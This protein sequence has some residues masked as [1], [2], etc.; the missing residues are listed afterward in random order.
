MGQ[1]ASTTGAGGSS[2]AGSV[3]PSLF[4]TGSVSHVDPGAPSQA[5]SPAGSPTAAGG[6]GVALDSAL[7]STPDTGPLPSASSPPPPPVQQRVTRLQHGISKPKQFTNGTVRWGM[8]ATSS[9]EPATVHVA[10]SDPRWVAAMDVEHEALQRNKTWH[11]VPRPR[12]KNVIGCK[13]V[14][15]VKRK[16]DGSIDRYKARLVA[17]GYRQR[18]GIDYEDTFSPV[19]KSTTIRLVLSVAVSQGWV[20]CQLDVQNAFL[21]GILNEEVYM[22]QPPGYTSQRYPEYVCKLDKAIYG[23]K[24][25]PRAWYARLC[26]KLVAL[27]FVPSKADTSLFSIT[28]GN[29]LYMSWYMLM[30]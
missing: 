10:L 27:G 8:S 15:K 14:Y 9:E 25:A 1:P 21:H 12:G 7:S 2:V 5:D 22:D 24:Q 11:L 28:K 4:G 29:M 16:S 19:V 30:I 17:K 26:A 6:S 18:Y 3:P 20:L 23:L 13:W